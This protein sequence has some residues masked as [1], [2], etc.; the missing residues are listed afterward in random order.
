MADKKND[1][2]K[3][4]AKADN[5][6][7]GSLA[8]KLKQADI[9]L[10]KPT[11]DK[12]ADR[13]RRVDAIMATAK[14]AEPLPP[15][16]SEDGLDLSDAQLFERALGAIKPEAIYPGKYHGEVTGLPKPPAPPVHTPARRI[17]QAE[18]LQKTFEEEEAREAVQSLRERSFF[19]RMVGGVEHIEDN[20]K[21]HVPEPKAPEELLD[22]ATNL[23]Y[24][25]EDSDELITPKMPKS[26]DGLHKVEA[27]AS[28]QSGLLKRFKL[29]ARR[30]S[31]EVLNVRGDTVEDA[32]RQVELFFH[33]H[34]K[35]NV[36]FVRV[37]H[38]RGLNSEEQLPVLKPTVLTWLEGPG[39]RYIRGYA[40]ELN[41]AGDYGSVIVQLRQRDTD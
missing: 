8:D 3:S 10:P 14:A 5:R 37:I 34:W 7:G 39:L 29:W 13:S 2:K 36:R 25:T 9:A 21:Y 23:P 6:F 31:V 15:A 35:L 18:R 11:T 24:T 41:T 20:A 40:P 33:K 4:A 1:K 38:G 22:R 27:L 28:S 30:E 17:T 12:K 19:E 32:L 16:P 26:G